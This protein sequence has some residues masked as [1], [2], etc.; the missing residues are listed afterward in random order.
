LTINPAIPSLKTMCSGMHG[1][2]RCYTHAN[3]SRSSTENV[4]SFVPSGE[5][6]SHSLN[7]LINACPKHI[8]VNSSLKMNLIQSGMLFFNIKP[9][10][11]RSWDI[12][13]EFSPC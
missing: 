7:S 4:I 3:M 1:R 10:S 12:L 13:P 5:K 9:G 6:S 2:V 11:T 8:L